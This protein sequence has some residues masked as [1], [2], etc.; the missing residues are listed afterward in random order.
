MLTR[1]DDGRRECVF[2]THHIR[3]MDITGESC[4]FV[5][6]G[7][8]QLAKSKTGRRDDSVGIVSRYTTSQ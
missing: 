4:G 7:Q 2:R 3:V 8:K 5:V 1:H 6:V